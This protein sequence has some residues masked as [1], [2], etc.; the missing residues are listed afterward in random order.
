MSELLRVMPFSLTAEHKD[1]IHNYQNREKK[2]FSIR[3][4]IEAGQLPA[5]AANGIL[6]LS[7]KI[8]VTERTEPSW[9][10]LLPLCKGILVER[11]NV[12]SHS[13]II[14]R[15]LGIPAIVGIKNLTSKLKNGDKINIDGGSGS[16]R[17]L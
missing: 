7:N 4:L 15:E 2:S 5:I 10:V 17:K 9:A 11:G 1:A 6:N 13:A 3:D 8:I 14:A 12:L 16:I